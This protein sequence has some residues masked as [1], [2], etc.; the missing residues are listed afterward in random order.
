MSEPFD[1]GAA[2]AAI[3]DLTCQVRMW[4]DVAAAE[5]EPGRAFALDQRDAAIA[6]LAAAGDAFNAGLRAEAAGKRT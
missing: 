2:V 6:K 3:A 5:T 1:F 4:A